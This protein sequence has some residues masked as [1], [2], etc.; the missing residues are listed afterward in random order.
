MANIIPVDSEEYAKLVMDSAD[1]KNTIELLKTEF[2][3]DTC[4][5][6]AIKAVLGVVEETTEPTDPSDPPSDPSTP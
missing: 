3:D 2:P 5:L 4:Q 1:K 6:I